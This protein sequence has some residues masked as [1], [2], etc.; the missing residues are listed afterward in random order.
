MENKD[1]LRDSLGKKQ[2]KQ[3]R[4]ISELVEGYTPYMNKVFHS[5]NSDFS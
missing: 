1:Q 4:S 3:F 5:K 2:E